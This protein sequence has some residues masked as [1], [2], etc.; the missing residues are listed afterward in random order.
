MS[1]LCMSSQV[2]LDGVRSI[3]HNVKANNVCPLT[4]LKKQWVYRRICV[5]VCTHVLALI[6]V[7]DGIVY[8]HGTISSCERRLLHARLCIFLRSYVKV[9][10]VGDRLMNVFVNC[11][12]R[13]LHQNRLS[14]VTWKHFTVIFF[15][16][17]EDKKLAS[18]E[19]SPFYK[20]LS[21]F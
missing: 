20:S 7:N 18:A 10:P 9:Y 11:S 5:R 19:I 6:S 8:S 14:F 13:Q 2:W 21:E 4:C 12:P 1:L 15:T 3:T 17:K 16:V